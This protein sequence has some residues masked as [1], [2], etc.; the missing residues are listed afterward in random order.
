MNAER[1]RQIYEVARA[2]SLIIL[3][4]DP[5]YYLKFESVETKAPTSTENSFLSIDEDGRVL[6]FDSFSKV[7]GS[8]KFVPSNICVFDHSL[9]EMF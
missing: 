6:R 2:H 3:E 7:R 4:D 8:H 5:Y 9:T 1:R